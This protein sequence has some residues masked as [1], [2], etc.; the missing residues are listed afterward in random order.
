M[1]FK[2]IITAIFCLLLLL[3]AFAS[4]DGLTGILAIA[5]WLMYVK[6]NKT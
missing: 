3:F 6:E 5:F 2:T 1:N 4:K